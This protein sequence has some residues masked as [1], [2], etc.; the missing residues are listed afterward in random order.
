MMHGRHSWDPIFHPT[1]L[2]PG[3]FYPNIASALQSTR[4]PCRCA[5][6]NRQAELAAIERFLASWGA[7]RCPGCLPRSSRRRAATR[8][9]IPPHQPAEIEGGAVMGLV[10]AGPVCASLA[11]RSALKRCFEV[12]E[13]ISSTGFVGSVPTP[14]LSH[15]MQQ[16]A[17]ALARAISHGL[18]RAGTP[19]G[20]RAITLS[21]RKWPEPRFRPSLNREASRL[22]D[23]RVRRPSFRAQVPET[24]RDQP[25]A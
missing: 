5:A 25:I 11:P 15:A 19:T 8:R 9:G 10:D 3:P 7:T 2:P 14:E 23:V 24:C 22:G 1:P 20:P 13:P 21:Q 17:L 6:V 4:P 12:G 16:C 18:A